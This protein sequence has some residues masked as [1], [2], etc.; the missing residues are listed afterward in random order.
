MCTYVRYWTISSL[1]H[2]M[3]TSHTF[4]SFQVTLMT[5]T[6]TLS[7]LVCPWSQEMG[8]LQWVTQRA[9]TILYKRMYTYVHMVHDTENLT[10]SE[11]FCGCSAQTPADSC[12]ERHGSSAGWQRIFLMGGH[13]SSAW[14]DTIFLRIR[15]ENG[16][17]QKANFVHNNNAGRIEKD[18][19]MIVRIIVVG[20]GLP[21]IFPRSTS[22][23][24]SPWQV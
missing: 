5:K 12:A 11:E 18:I 21:L 4:I 23:W 7:F 19:A 22:R 13:G 10:V 24:S 6:K 3:P 17:N 2:N 9:P 14:P 20:I 8:D 16:G 1:S 15:V